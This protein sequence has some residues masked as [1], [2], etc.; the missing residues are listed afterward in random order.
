MENPLELRQLILDVCNEVLNPPVTG[1][2]K[3]EE[4]AKKIL[5]HFASVRISKITPEMVTVLW[6]II[7]KSDFVAIVG[8]KEQDIL[9]QNGK[10]PAELSSAFVGSAEVY[11]FGN[12]IAYLCM[13]GAQNGFAESAVSF[14]AQANQMAMS[15]VKS[16]PVAKPKIEIVS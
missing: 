6:S 7:D 16:L 2:L 8:G 12:A 1:N 5:E 14:L 13:M 4:K 11:N 10:K 15:Q 9:N 3:T